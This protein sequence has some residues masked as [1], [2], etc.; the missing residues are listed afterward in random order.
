MGKVYVLTVGC[1]YEAAH[2]TIVFESFESAE[3]Y[4]LEQEAY[5]LE[6]EAHSIND[7]YEFFTNAQK[8]NRL[9]S[10]GSFSEYAGCVASTVGD[11][12]VIEEMEMRP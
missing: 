8:L 2:T 7:R 12:C 9:R 5:Q 1:D 3:A 10:L 6:Q 4:Q 11:L